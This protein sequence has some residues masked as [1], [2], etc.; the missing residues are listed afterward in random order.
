MADY[1]EKCHRAYDED[2]IRLERDGAVLAYGILKYEDRYVP[3]TPTQARI[4]GV[5]MRKGRIS[6]DL[7]RMMFDDDVE[8]VDTLMR[9]FIWQLRTKLKKAGAPFHI[10]TQWG[11]GYYLG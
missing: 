5:L 3:I 1:C 11:I 10:K 7:L 4:L 6:N 8:H 9:V 2:E